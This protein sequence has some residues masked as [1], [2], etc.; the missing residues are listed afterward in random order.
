MEIEVRKQ[1]LRVSVCGREV[2]N[3]KLDQLADEAGAYPGLKSRSGHVGFGKGVGVAR[4]RNIEIKELKPASVP[5]EKKEPAPKAAP[6]SAAEKPT[7][8]ATPDG[9]VSL[10]NGKDLTGWKTHPVAPGDW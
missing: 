10:F 7:P 1:S 3:V 5:Q 6:K 4:F 8:K 2:S 9:W